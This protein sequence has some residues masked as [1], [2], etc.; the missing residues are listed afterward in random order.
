VP[1]MAFA[2]PKQ[3]RLLLVPP[4]GRTGTTTLQASLDVADWPVATAFMRCRRSASTAGSRPSPGASYR[5]P[6]VSPGRTCTGWLPSACRS[7]TPCRPPR[8]HGAQAAGR[9]SEMPGCPGGR[10][11]SEA[12][13][14]WTARY[15]H[16]V[17]SGLGP[18]TRGRKPRPAPAPIEWGR[19]HFWLAEEQ[20][21]GVTHLIRWAVPVAFGGLLAACGGVGTTTTTPPGAG[22]TTTP[23]G[24]ITGVASP[25]VGYAATAGQMA[26]LPVRVTLTEG[27]RTVTSVIVRGSHTYRFTEP[28][29]RYIVSSDQSGVTPTGVNLRPSEVAHIDLISPCM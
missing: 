8:L 12:F 19:P 4:D 7:V 17:P 2:L 22:T 26:K 5:D 1:S 11:V 15:P 13:R 10:V 27:P 28:P 23:P 9:T 14:S 25:C 24:V 3:A 16:R 29:G 18:S 21:Q 6:G 20:D